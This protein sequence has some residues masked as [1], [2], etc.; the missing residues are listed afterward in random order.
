MPTFYF[1][2]SDGRCSPDTD[3]HYFTDDMAARREAMRRVALLLRA[4]QNGQGNVRPWRIAVRNEAGAVLFKIEAPSA[5][6]FTPDFA[7]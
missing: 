7:H 5:M 4:T 6:H 1:D 3:G 2:V